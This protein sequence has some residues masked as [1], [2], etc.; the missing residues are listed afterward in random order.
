[1]VLIEVFIVR[2]CFFFFLVVG[3]AA[4]NWNSGSSN[5][6]RSISCYVS[7]F[8]LLCSY[9]CAVLQKVWGILCS[10]SIFQLITVALQVVSGKKPW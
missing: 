1:M 4:F 10:A 6:L 5:C 8:C 9:F 3:S 7:V 2:C